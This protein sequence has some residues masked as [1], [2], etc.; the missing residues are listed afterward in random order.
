MVP[1]WDLHLLPWHQILVAVRE[2]IQVPSQLTAV[3]ASRLL[4]GDMQTA[5]NSKELQS[6][7]TSHLQ[8]LLWSHQSFPSSWLTE[9]NNTDYLY[10]DDK[11]RR[12]EKILLMLIDRIPSYITKMYLWLQPRTFP[13][14]NAFQLWPSLL[15]LNTSS[16]G[17]CPREGAKTKYLLQ[18]RQSSAIARFNAS[19]SINLF[20]LSFYFTC[21]QLAI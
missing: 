10:K 4:T 11:H 18:K 17:L 6:F 5:R 16:A 7:V 9:M 19:S 13:V 8:S 1:N 12:D 20:W 2:N 21:S 15:R 14:A 3:N